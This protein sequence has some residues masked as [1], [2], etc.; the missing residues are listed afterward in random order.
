MEP[1]AA[2]DQQQ[3]AFGQTPWQTVGPFFH[4]CLPWSGCADLMAPSQIGAR[5]DLIPPGYQALQGPVRRVA[6]QMPPGDRIEVSGRVLDAHGAPVP[7]ALLELW[8][9][10]ASGAYR[11]ATAGRDVSLDA[12]DA[13][14]F[15][16][17]RAATAEDG[18]FCFR[19]LRPG[20]VLFAAGRPELQAPHLALG[21]LGRGLLKRLV[22]RIYFDD[23]PSN[24]QDPILARVPAQRRATLIAARI[25]ALAGGATARYR[26]DIRLQ[27]EHETV[28]FE[29]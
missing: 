9:A 16:F 1:S 3:A 5:A 2:A 24:A 7:D 11:G 21:V 23:E 28:F 18:A 20:R 26:F 29:W 14:F 22:T 6:P 17:G 15:G 27:G 10:D 25:D 8:Q 4:F 13:A 19:T 12:L